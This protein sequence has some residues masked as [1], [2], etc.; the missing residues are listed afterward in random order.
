M[1]Q[2]TF[3]CCLHFFS[4]RRS[5]TASNPCPSCCTSLSLRSGFARHGSAAVQCPYHAPKTLSGQTGCAAEQLCEARTMTLLCAACLPAV[6][7]LSKL[8]TYHGV[9]VQLSASTSMDGLHVH[10]MPAAVTRAL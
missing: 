5:L 9:R 6:N 1:H 8:L 7:C 10:L 2:L 4:A 3:W